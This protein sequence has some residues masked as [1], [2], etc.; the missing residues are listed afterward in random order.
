MMKL[1]TFLGQQWMCYLLSIADRS[2]PEIGKALAGVSLVHVV[3]NGAL[4]HAL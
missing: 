1:G 3:G 2:N 4:E